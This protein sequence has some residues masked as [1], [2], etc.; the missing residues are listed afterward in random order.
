MDHRAFLLL[1]AVRAGQPGMG[2]PLEHMHYDRKQLWRGPEVSPEANIPT[3]L[4]SLDHSFGYDCRRR[5]NLQLLEESTL[6]FIAGNFL[7]FLD[8]CARKQRYISSCSGEGIGAIMVH[9]SRHF[10]AVAEKGNRPNIV[11]YEFPSLQPFRILRG[12]TAWVYTT[13]AFDHEGLLLA[14]VGG[15]PDYMLTLWA[16]REERVLLRCKAASQ[17]VYRISFSSDSPAQLTTSGAGHIKFWK[18]ASSFTGLKLQG[19]LGR[20]GRT[21]PTDIEGYVEFPDGKV[22][23]GSE[24][25]NMLL[26]EGALIKVEICRRGGRPCHNGAIRQFVLDEGEILTVG[27]DGAIRAWHFESMDG[28]DSSDGSDL[29]ELE[30]MNEVLVGRGVCLVSMVKGTTQGS[31]IWFAQD[32]G[33]AVWKLDLSFSNMTRDPEA[34]FTFHSGPIVSMD[35]SRTSHLMA[36]SAL[37][38]SVRV[39]DLLAQRELIC[40]RFRQNATTVTWE[41]R[42]VRYYICGQLLAVGFEDGL[43]RLLEFFL[44]PEEGGY[45][46]DGAQLQLRQAVKPHWGPV[47]AIAFHSSGRLLATGSK[48]GTVFFFVVG[49]PYEAIGLITVP[50]PVCSLQWAPPSQGRKALLILCENG[51]VVEVGAPEPGSRA[52][53]HHSYELEDLPRMHFH[54]HSVKSH[55]RR[56]LPQRDEEVTRRKAEKQKRRVEEEQQLKESLEEKEPW[57]EEEDLPPLYIPDPPSPLLCGFYSGPGSFWLSMGGFDAG[58]LYHCRFSSQQE[59]AAERR[60]DEPFA[61]VPLGH[62]E[63]DAVQCVSISCGG[64]LLLCGMQTGRL[65][66]YPL[67]LEDPHLCSLRASWVLGV[68]YSQ[69]GTVRAIRCSHDDRFVLTVGD[70]GNIFSFSLLAPWGGLG[71]PQDQETASP[72]PPLPRQKVAQDIEDPQAYSLETA[73]QCTELERLAQEAEHRKVELRRELVELQKRFRELQ[74]RTRELPSHTVPRVAETQRKLAWEREWYRLSLKKLQDRLGDPLESDTI[75]VVAFHSPHRVSTCRIL[76]PS[77]EQQIHGTGTGPE[78]RLPGTETEPGG[79]AAPVQAIHWRKTEMNSQVVGLRDSKLQ[80]LSQLRIQMQQLQVV[81]VQ[82]PPALCIA[83]PT[84]LGPLPEETPKQKL[85]PSPATLLRLQSLHARRAPPGGEREELGLLELLEHAGGEQAEHDNMP[86]SECPPCQSIQLEVLFS[87]VRPC[88]PLQMSQDI[89]DFDTRLKLLRHG[90]LKLDVKLKLWDL[91]HITLYQELLLLRDFETREDRLQEA[92]RWRQEEWWLLTETRQQLQVKQQEV[93]H[94]QEQEKVLNATFQALLG[95]NNKWGPFLTKVF[96]KKVKRVKKREKTGE[97]GEHSAEESEG[98]SDWDEDEDSES[99]SVDDTTCPPNCDLDLFEGTIQL[100]ESRLELEELLAEERKNAEFLRKESVSV[101][102]SVSIFFLTVSV[103]C[104]KLDCP[105]SPQIEFLHKGLIP[106]KL[107]QALV[108][109]ISALAG[110]QERIIQLQVEQSHQK[111]LYQKARKQHVQLN[112]DC[113]QMEAR[114]QGL[115]CEQLMQKKFGRPVDLEVLQTLCRSRILEEMWQ[116]RSANGAASAQEMQL[117]CK[118]A[119][120]EMTRQHTEALWAMS[121]LLAQKKELENRLDTRQGKMVPAASVCQLLQR[122]ACEIQVLQVEI[123]ALLRKGGHPPCPPPPTTPL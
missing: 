120:M 86:I 42:G 36:T 37:D 114:I 94:L 105:P 54:F 76:T 88:P 85:Q 23:S 35:V 87:I 32:S 123:C 39:F 67:Q 112:H 45:S 65:R 117:W 72:P 91:Q 44:P 4:L 25:G 5:A 9:P 95:P 46:P 108:L 115:Q 15:A 60:H 61:V 57:G 7:V 63:D 59:Q 113:K 52:P 28:A 14:S 40:S 110:L 62:G 107:T 18:M 48:D 121:N 33:G 11:V 64:Q 74:W 21:T 17:D 12:G 79:V 84:I 68:H 78:K 24:W 47:S 80:L 6:T 20:F 118:R 43:L 97:I 16:W 93:A 50:G 66:A 102:V 75:N 69:N 101:W 13:L 3:D 53:R 90:K 29:F 109:N 119:V 103:L 10:L 77:P 31:S 1:C 41:P 106:T 82:L 49:D 8:V 71:I 56:F 98:E 2:C 30:P 22:L 111:A 51:H 116:E 83:P 55:I 100:R 122:Q 34:I 104:F 73:R 92:L 70:D 96:R 81:Q 89:S 99:G 38:R 27:I 26:W 19:Q 58:F